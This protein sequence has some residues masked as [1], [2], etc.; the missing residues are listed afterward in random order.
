MS[1]ASL[2]AQRIL[3]RGAAFVYMA[4]LMSL[5]VQA[6]GLFG[7]KG[8]EPLGV[9]QR[10]ILLTGI[11]FLDSPSL[12]RLSTHPAFVQSVFLAGYT[13][14]LLAALN[15]WP[16]PAY[17]VMWFIYAS[18]LNSVPSFLSYQW[19]NLL[20]ET[21]F[22]LAVLLP[23]RR[24]A[25]DHGLASG[26]RVW[27]IRLI[28]TKLM[29]QSGLVKLLSGDP[30]WRN[31]TAMQYHY[32]TQPL[33]NPVSWFA[34]HLPDWWHRI[35]TLVA[36]LI[37]VVVP[38]MVFLG[39]RARRSAGAA[40]VFLQ[41]CILLTGNYGFFNVLTA[42]LCAS[43]WLE[44]RQGKESGPHR[45]AVGLIALCVAALLT[46]FQF[47]A[48]LLGYLTP[49]QRL[50]WRFANTY[51]ISCPYGLFAVMTTQRPELVLEVSV[52]GHE[53][54]EVQFR[55]KP[56][57]PDLRPPV[58]L[59]H[60]PRLDWQMW[61]AA[62]S[63]ASEPWLPRFLELLVTSKPDGLLRLFP[64]G[65]REKL[66]GARHARLVAYDYRFSEPAEWRAKGVWWVRERIRP[67]ITVSAD[68]VVIHNYQTLPE[69]GAR[70]VS[71]NGPGMS[72]TASRLADCVRGQ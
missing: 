68:E 60:M 36:L 43:L 50:L 3:T 1:R 22:W 29:L 10:R 45:D 47:Q 42:V 23:W 67:L 9:T 44:P 30:T 37:E 65:E 6:D 49:P 27:G 40:F 7:P 11:S 64:A 25:P 34:Y 63:P 46:L 71:G 51:R 26:W 66:L 8:I 12:F 20:C 41:A 21:C 28:V 52:D 4:A 17:L 58:V 32:M 16:G 15:W 31:L 38:V 53:W 19:D 70:G 56:G 54:E 14:A 72:V 55:F 35:E 24:R 59:M 39:N 57:A 62:L 33:P 5:H 48:M 13:A 61:F 2:V 69:G 18:F